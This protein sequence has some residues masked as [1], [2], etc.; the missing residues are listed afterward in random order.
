[1]EERSR[2]LTSAK[3]AAQHAQQDIGAKGPPSGDSAGKPSRRRRSREVTRNKLIAAALTVFARKG[4]ESSTINDITEEADVGFGSFYNYF[5]SKT[6]IA[7]C[8][9]KARAEEVATIGDVIADH[10]N[11]PAVVVAYI[12]RVFLTKAVTD[13]VWGWFIIHASHS[14]PELTSIFME[15]GKRDIRRGVQ[16][17][18]FS[19]EHEDTAMRIVLSALQGMMRAILENEVPPSAVDETIEYLLIMLGIDEQDARLLSRNPLPRYVTQLF[20]ES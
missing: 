12:Q 7:T 5:T 11:D 19:V 6:E 3:A 14:L 20:Q 4:I 1:M 9:L 8:V 16:Q 18:R 13:P 2:R 17:G 10:E 15:H